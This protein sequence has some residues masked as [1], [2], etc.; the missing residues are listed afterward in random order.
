MFKK[1]MRMTRAL[2]YEMSGPEVCHPTEQV[3]DA[4]PHGDQ[5][6][7]AEHDGFPSVSWLG[8]LGEDNARHTGL[9]EDPSHALDAHQQDGR[10]TLGGGGPSSVPGNI[11]QSVITWGI[12]IRLSHPMVC[13]VSTL[14]RKAE[15]K[16]FMF[17]TQ[18]TWSAPRS[19][20]GSK[21]PGE[22]FLTDTT[23]WEH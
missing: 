7:P 18:T 14:K 21:S 17:S 23:E 10:A 22:L 19:L 4:V 8:E 13:W 3:E 15:V 20:S 6:G 12:R 9:Y 16:S 1:Q 11:S 2:P 5:S